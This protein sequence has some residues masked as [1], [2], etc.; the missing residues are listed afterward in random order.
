MKKDAKQIVEA[1]F[2]VSSCS[3]AKYLPGEKQ[4][5]QLLRDFS[6]DCSRLI[7][8]KRGWRSL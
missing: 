6:A 3:Y 8:Q 2:I 1:L 5:E 7:G 4:D